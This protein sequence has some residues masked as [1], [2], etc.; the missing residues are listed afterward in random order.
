M[1][2]L[3][4]KCGRKEEGR[5]RKKNVKPRRRTRSTIVSSDLIAR[6]PR[7]SSRF[8]FSEKKRIHP[9]LSPR[10]P[11]DY[12]I[13]RE[14]RLRREGR[15]AGARSFSDSIRDGDPGSLTLLIGEPSPR[16]VNRRALDRGSNDVATAPS[17]A[18]RHFSFYASPREKEIDTDAPPRS[19][20]G[21]LSF[22]FVLIAVSPISSRHYFRNCRDE[23]ESRSRFRLP[24]KVYN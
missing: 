23:E 19:N 24:R 16:L 6:D 13:G 12:A 15:G 14:P 8:N 10:W 20:R 11:S 22:R 1:E 2:I 5:E 9:V 4:G 3:G 18:N 17:F 21:D 7:V